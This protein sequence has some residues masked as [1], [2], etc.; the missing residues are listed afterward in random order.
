M[1]EK[2]RTT[3]HGQQDN[4]PSR[5]SSAEHLGGRLPSVVQQIAALMNSL[6]EHLVGRVA[7]GTPS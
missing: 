7:P 5:D 1:R 4:L 6:A 3:T 2:K